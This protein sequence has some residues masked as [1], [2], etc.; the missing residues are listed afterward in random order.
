M[1]GSEQSQPRS[2]HAA[3]MQ[4]ARAAITDSLLLR[5]NEQQEDLVG[6]YDEMQIDAS[7]AMAKVCS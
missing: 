1:A 7:G 2:R 5:S 4:K 3:R 6:I